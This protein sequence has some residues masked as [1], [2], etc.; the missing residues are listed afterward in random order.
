[1]RLA[2]AVCDYGCS[3][4]GS[5][6]M[7]VVARHLASGLIPDRKFYEKKGGEHWE[8]KFYSI[9]EIL[10]GNRFILRLFMAGVKSFSKGKFT[11]RFAS[12]EEKKS[13]P[14]STGNQIH[15]ILEG[16]DSS[17]KLFIGNCSTPFEKA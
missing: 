11:L 4:T 6:L 2:S 3:D 17:I 16:D 10:S 7:E 9:G 13:F 8:E 5:E 15:L 12:K 1:M 14:S